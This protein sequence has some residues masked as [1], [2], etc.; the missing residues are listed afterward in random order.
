MISWLLTNALT[1]LLTPPGFL[2]IALAAGLTLRR[3]LP[4]TSRGLL[5]TG[6]TGLYLLSMPLT[7]TFLLQQ[8][9]TPHRAAPASAPAQAIVVLGGGRYPAAP[10]Y[11]GDTVSAATLVRLRYAAQL[12]RDTGLPLL[13]SGGSPD[14]SRTNEAELMAQVL[15]QSFRV[16]VRWRE[17]RS[18]NTLENARLSRETLAQENIDRIHLVTHAWHMPRSILV[19]ERAGFEVIPATTAHATGE[20]AKLTALDFLP[21]F[22]GLRDSSIFFHEAIGMVWYRLRL[23]AQA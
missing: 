11:G 18:A 16:P 5:I 10:E 4:R 12:H 19:F 21:N 15:E 8:W 1:A 20:R 2:F 7:G 3:R 6:T 9:E 17:G 14:G 22:T 23:L 13:V